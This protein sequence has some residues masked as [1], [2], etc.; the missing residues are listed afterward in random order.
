MA[1]ARKMELVLINSAFLELSV[2]L[3]SYTSK[4]TT[5]TLSPTIPSTTLNLFA[6]TDWQYSRALLQT[7]Q[8]PLLSVRLASTRSMDHVLALQMHQQ[9]LAA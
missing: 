9:V 4:P 1:V 2:I 8:H 3:H 6:R 5:T 7:L